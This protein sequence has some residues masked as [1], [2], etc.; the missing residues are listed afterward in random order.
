MWIGFFV[1]LA[2]PLAFLAFRV[3]R[4][5]NQVQWRV[6]ERQGDLASKQYE[7]DKAARIFSNALDAA[8]EPPPAR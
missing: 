4:N 3:A 7:W 1:V 8:R 6:L 2:I 5:W